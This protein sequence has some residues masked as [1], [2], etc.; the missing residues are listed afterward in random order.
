MPATRIWYFARK[1][2]PTA[3]PHKI[4]AFFWLWRS[5]E[6]KKYRAPEKKK[7]KAVSSIAALESQKNP[8]VTPSTTL[9]T[10]AVFGP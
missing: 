8:G 6:K 3:I 1:P 5:Q 9:A 7:I 2:T 10:R 4:S